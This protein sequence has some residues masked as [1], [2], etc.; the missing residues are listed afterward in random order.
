MGK[1][2]FAV[3]VFVSVTAAFSYT[4]EQLQRRLDSLELLQQEAIRGGG[5]GKEFSVEKKQLQ[6]AIETK[7]NELKAEVVKKIEGISDSEEVV[8]K[9]PQK[10]STQNF[11]ANRSLL[12][13]LVIIMGAIAVASAI[14]LVFARIFLAVSK[15]NKEKKILTAKKTPQ[16]EVK[17]ELAPKTANETREIDRN[18]RENVPNIEKVTYSIRDLANKIP[19]K[20]ALPKFVIETGTQAAVPEEK[21]KKMRAVELKNEIVKRFDNG[22]DTAKIA[23]DFSMSKDQVVMIL[24]LAGRK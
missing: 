14:F 17:I 3:Y 23:H 6:M 8:K 13:N 22:E 1:L 5:D 10:N 9:T 21:P 4:F 15:K 2:F 24:N 19:P 7:N 18:N 12:D 11:F 20:D 16:T